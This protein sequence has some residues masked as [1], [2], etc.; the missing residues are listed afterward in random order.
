MTVVLKDKLELLHIKSKFF[1]TK[2]QFLLFKVSFITEAE[3]C[4]RVNLYSLSNMLVNENQLFK[5]G[6]QVSLP[7]WAF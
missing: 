4:S 6:P 1:C 5:M 7:P 3:K 2:V